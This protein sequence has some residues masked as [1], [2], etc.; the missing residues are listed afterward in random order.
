M[1]EGDP[2]YG[3]EHDHAVTRLKAKVV[4]CGIF[5]CTATPKASARLATSTALLVTLAAIS[6]SLPDSP[7]TFAE[8][9]VLAAPREVPPGCADSESELEARETDEHDGEDDRVEHNSP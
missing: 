5:D 2:R 9:A 4:G 6:A 8:N 7:A 1:G 3:A